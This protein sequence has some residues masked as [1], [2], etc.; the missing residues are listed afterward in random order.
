MSEKNQIVGLSPEDAFKHTFN[1]RVKSS[2]DLET[3]ENKKL[4]DAWHEALQEHGKHMQHDS[5]KVESPSQAE[6]RLGVLVLTNP[7]Q[8]A[9]VRY[10]APTDAVEIAEKIKPLLNL[11]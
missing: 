1:G 6:A 4:L 5:S 7:Q 8:L 2:V 11:S 3:S 9:Y 10:S